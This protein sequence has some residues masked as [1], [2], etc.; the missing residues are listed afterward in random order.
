MR[1][2][3][4]NQSSRLKDYKWL[5]AIFITSVFLSC[6]T[7][8]KDAVNIKKINFGKDYYIFI[9]ESPNTYINCTY[10]S[11]WYL[12]NFDFVV[13]NERIKKRES[14]YLFVE[15][16]LIG[17]DKVDLIATSYLR[18]SDV[19]CVNDT[20]FPTESLE[21]SRTHIDTSFMKFG[22]YFMYS[23]MNYAEKENI[24]FDIIIKNK[25]NKIEIIIFSAD[26]ELCE[27]RYIIPAKPKPVRQ[28]IITKIKKMQ[29]ISEV[30]KQ[31][32][33]QYFLKFLKG[34]IVKK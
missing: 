17:K 32:F 13:N 7:L 8:N 3:N 29:R 5:T 23:S 28:K 25:L 31:L 9:R 27:Q 1:H 11:E 20:V 4:Q 30:E 26:F 22:L 33:E 16:Y 2:M 19:C 34:K 21:K 24:Q 10:T 15:E 6:N 14:S 12:K 18:Y